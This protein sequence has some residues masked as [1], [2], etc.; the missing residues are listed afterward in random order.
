MV[1]KDEET[2]EHAIMQVVYVKQH[3]STIVDFHRQTQ[4]PGVVRV[5]TCVPNEFLSAKLKQVDVTV[6]HI[7]HEVNATDGL[8]SNVGIA[9]IECKSVDAFPDTLRWSFDGLTGLRRLALHQRRF[10]KMPSTLCSW[11]QGRIMHQSENLCEHH[12]R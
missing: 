5:P 4:R 6:K 9:T 7:A 8:M 12:E 1:F 10:A 2:K 3:R 11:P